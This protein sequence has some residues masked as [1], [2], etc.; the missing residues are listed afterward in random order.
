MIKL[1]EVLCLW[2]HWHRKT[3][4]AKQLANAL[5]VELVL[6]DMSEYLRKA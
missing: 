4:T 3:E 1:L 2:A 6:S 5:S